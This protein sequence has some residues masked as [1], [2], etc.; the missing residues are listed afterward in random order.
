MERNRPYLK[1]GAA[2]KEI[3]RG[4]KAW[5]PGIITNVDERLGNAGLRGAERRG[6]ELEYPRRAINKFV[7]ERGRANGLPIAHRVPRVHSTL[8]KQSI[9][10]KLITGHGGTSAVL[11]RFRVHGGA[12]ISLNRRHIV[13]HDAINMDVAK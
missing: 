11:I 3:S 13:P 8:I 12:R 10:I 7:S 6:L 1:N 5:L 9:F 2:L 4:R